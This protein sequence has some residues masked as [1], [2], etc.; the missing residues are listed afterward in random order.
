MGVTLLCVEQSVFVLLPNAACAA[1]AA[2]E[3][4]TDEA[5]N[6]TIAMTG[7]LLNMKGTSLLSCRRVD[8]SARLSSRNESSMGSRKKCSRHC[9]LV[10]P[11]NSAT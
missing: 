11:T 3:G 9:S 1:A 5:R 7:F 10:L 4:L 8:A 6:E 2:T